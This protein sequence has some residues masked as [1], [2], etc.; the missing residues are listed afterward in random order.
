MQADMSCIMT[1]TGAPLFLPATNSEDGWDTRF[2]APSPAYILLLGSTIDALLVN[3]NDL[4]LG[5]LGGVIRWDGKEAP[6][7]CMHRA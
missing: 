4:Y 7:A 3:G 6:R 2:S 5:G 1:S